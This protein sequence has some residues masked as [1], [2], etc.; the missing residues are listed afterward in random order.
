MGKRLS[1][2]A[3]LLFL[4]GIS[5]GYSQDVDTDGDGMPDAWET[6][7]GLNPRNRFDAN[8]DLDGDK[9]RNIDEYKAGTNPNDK[10]V[11][12]NGD[13]V[14]DDWMTFYHLTDANADADG[15][16]MSNKE[17]YVA[18]TVP[19]DPESVVKQETVTTTQRQTPSMTGVRENVDA[20]I[21]E[22]HQIRPNV[23]RYNDPIGD[24][25][26]PGYYT[27]PTNPVYV[28]GAFD[29]V[30]FEVDATSRDN[31]VFKI[32]VNADLKQDWGMSADFDVQYFQIY[33]D[34]D[35][36][37][38]SGEVRCMPGLNVFFD[39]NSAWDKV[40]LVSPQP[41]A[42]VQVEVD[43]KA[44]DMAN[45]VTIPIKI[46]GQGRT[47]TAVVKKKDLGVAA[48]G[49][50]SGWAYQVVAQS[51]EGF[52]DSDDLLTRN[53][54]EF[55][56]LHRFGGG[57]DYWGD[58]ELMDILVWPARGTLQE[59][60]DQFAMLNVW[61]SSPDPMMDVKAVLPMVRNNE[62]EQ[63][64]PSGGYEAF[65]RNL[66]EKL[67][68][69]PQKD[70]YVSDNFTF[71]G[72]VNAQW[73][74]NLDN[75][76]V[77]PTHPNVFGGG[78]LN[79]T[80]KPEAYYD[81]H[82]YS[83]FTLEF[84]GKVFTD[85]VNFYARLSSYWDP[86]AQWDYWRGNYYRD[87]HGPQYVP[88]NF[89]SFRFQIIKPIPTVDYVSIGNY[90]YGLSPWTIGPSSY[91]DRDKYKGIFLDGSSEV[92][93][94]VYNVGYFYP[95][96]WLGINWDL[97]E[98]TA[99]D[100]VISGLFQFEPVKGLKFKTTGMLYSDWEVGEDNTNTG[101]TGLARRLQNWAVDGDLMINLKLGDT[102]LSI[103]GQG[104]FAQYIRGTNLV[105]G[106]V[107]EQGAMDIPSGPS[108]INGFFG[109]GTI[110]VDNILG[111]A[112]NLRAQGFY[113]KDYYSV[114]ASRG[115]YANAPRQDVLLMY[116]N[117][118]AH[119]YPQDAAPFQKWD[120][121][122][123]ESVANG[124]WYGGTGIL[125]WTAGL[126]KLHGEYSMWGFNNTNWN[127]TPDQPITNGQITYA[128]NSG[129]TN[130]I[131]NHTLGY[132]LRGYFSATY[133]L[134]IGGG[135]DLSLS[136]LYNGTKNWWPMAATSH[137]R[138]GMDGVFSFNYGFIYDSNLPKIT[139]YYQFSKLFRA[140]VGFQFRYDK[141]HD[142][143]PYNPYPDYYVKGYT[144]IL[145]FIYSTPL[146]QLRSYIQGYIADNPRGVPYGGVTSDDFRIPLEYQTQKFNVVA[147]TELDIYF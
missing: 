24:D 25:K 143:Y 55:R 109:V 97:G 120:N 106:T 94:I 117:Q 6:Q 103:Q 142:L 116:G 73:Y 48:D 101:Q 53:V 88:I 62:T 104:G 69:P 43:V 34:Q 131:T 110:R 125:E 37:P 102:G 20:S 79:E 99:R 130:A 64:M 107:L 77:T 82:I 38:G 123:W 134:D 145:D 128:V 3:C 132:G 144:L 18:G 108:N 54:N 41:N 65:A 136:Y 60:T 9:I 49:D 124:G 51:N 74:Y 92:M 59:A 89:E 56:G 80:F 72:S 112:I 58:P 96:P 139:A 93:N 26:G 35:G 129:S 121:V 137:T 16:G 28:P 87:T 27:Y 98:Y 86:D 21:P 45:G 4:I 5:F 90:E 2:I 135:L 19:T 105:D 95:F 10:D 81:N 78:G 15:D 122:M 126:L 39:P 31:V 23:F 68:P 71:S 33:I 127:Q 76:A 111:T 52:P 29:I 40:V 133:K 113:V 66:S 146:G 57:S 47:I 44:K 8:L 22:N 61:S 13:G 12:K 14:A 11:D 91:P 50:I 114:M 36:V 100:N 30:S 42:R 138:A 70:K 147:L 118:S 75:D 83:R 63:W 84:Y 1:L 7:Y 115:D 141:I 67:K 17:E 140:G 85:M 119:N 46:T 32:T